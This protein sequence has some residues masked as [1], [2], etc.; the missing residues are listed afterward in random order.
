MNNFNIELFNFLQEDLTLPIK[1]KKHDKWPIFIDKENYL[2]WKK[3][4]YGIG[5]IIGPP[6]HGWF[7]QQWM[8]RLHVGCQLSSYL[9]KP[10]LIKYEILEILLKKKILIELIILILEYY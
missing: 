2:K 8:E 9:I 7:F 6:I 10:P 4:G 1:E 5:G 3:M